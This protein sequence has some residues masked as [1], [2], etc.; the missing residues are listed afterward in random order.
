MQ[1]F[2]PY[3]H[4]RYNTAKHLLMIR[5]LC[6][7]HAYAL[8]LLHLLINVFVNSFL[9]A[10]VFGFSLMVQNSS[11]NC[12]HYQNFAKGC[13]GNKADQDID[14][15]LNLAY[16]VVHSANYYGLNDTNHDYRIYNNLYHEC[17]NCNWQMTV[18]YKL[19]HY[20]QN[21]QVCL[22]QPNV[23]ESYKNPFLFDSAL[24]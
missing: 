24:R 23:M 18:H 12:I 22:I 2:Q 1:L 10:F 8:V 15:V 14:T 6:L 7:K 21:N 5:M 11:V 13:T 16:V 3:V 17:L 4:R 20:D 9:H 19:N